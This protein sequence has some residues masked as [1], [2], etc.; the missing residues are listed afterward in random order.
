[1]T[2]ANLE[3]GFLVGSFLIAMPGMGDPRFSEAV[4]LMSE[5]SE[6]GA[7]GFIVNKPLDGIR[8]A[9]LAEQLDIEPSGELRDVPVLTGGP[10]ERQRGF[11]LHSPDYL[12]EA[13]T[14]PVSTTFSVTAH[15][16]I[17]R[18]LATGG[19]PVKGV[20]AL[21]YAGWGPGQLEDELRENAWLVAP[22]EGAL[23]F[24]L[25]PDQRWAAAMNAAGIDL[26]K[27]SGAGGT[28]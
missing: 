16:D 9:D 11:V 28:A 15:A 1:M 2:D 17:L 19:G 4:I 14:Q 25:P 3:D 18:A 12:L 27:L 22:A 13:E 6:T 21:G 26:A 23:V 8:F 20:L 5:H 10:V 24:D 7:M